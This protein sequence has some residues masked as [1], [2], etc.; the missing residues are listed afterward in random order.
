MAAGEPATSFRPRLAYLGRLAVGSGDGAVLIEPVIAGEL[1]II[2]TLA[3]G[4]QSAGLLYGHACFDDEGGYTLIDGFVPAAAAGSIQPPA[5]PAAAAALLREEAAR[6]YPGTTKVGW[7]RT[8]SRPGA[9]RPPETETAGWP[10]GERPAGVGLVVFAD[11]TP[12]AADTTSRRVVQ[13]SVIADWPEDA[14]YL[15]AP[16]SPP[17][18]PE[19]EPVRSWELPPVYSPRLV[20]EAELSSRRRREPPPR[21]RVLEAQQ[22]VLLAMIILIIAVIVTVCVMV[23]NALR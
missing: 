12:P 9:G 14:P 6:S 4:L 7:W 22:W 19:P 2:A 16:E 18:D 21:E 10:F 20:Q 15:S 23:S 17:A 3:G 5:D 11:G 1:R 13:G 8:A